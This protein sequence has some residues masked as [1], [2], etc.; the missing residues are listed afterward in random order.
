MLCPDLRV[1]KKEIIKKNI[2]YPSS[3]QDNNNSLNKLMLPSNINK[4]DN[5]SHRFNNSR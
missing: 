5:I 1:G 3:S 4:Q 2:F